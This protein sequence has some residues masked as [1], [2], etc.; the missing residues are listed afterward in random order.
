MIIMFALQ[1]LV[2]YLNYSEGPLNS[3][4]WKALVLLLQKLI[5]DPDTQKNILKWPG[6]S[7]AKPPLESGIWKLAASMQRCKLKS[8]LLPILTCHPVL[9]RSIGGFYKI[10]LRQSLLEQRCS[11][12]WFGF[13]QTLGALR[14]S[15]VFVGQE[16][17]PC[18]PGK[19]VWPLYAQIKTGIPTHA[20]D[21]TREV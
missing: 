2:N 4:S 10:S 6:I 13:S 18:S 17:K 21:E 15:A 8:S 5:E 20:H 7:H 9:E 19:E 14:Q 16:R 12:F 1:Q 3:E 11:T